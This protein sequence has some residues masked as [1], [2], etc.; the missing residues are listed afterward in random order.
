MNDPRLLYVRLNSAVHAPASRTLCLMQRD[1][2][3]TPVA[4]VLRGRVDQHRQIPGNQPSTATTNT[5]LRFSY[6][7][8]DGVVRTGNLTIS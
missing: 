2:F 7:G 1:N 8:S 5:N 6:R 3:T 4:A